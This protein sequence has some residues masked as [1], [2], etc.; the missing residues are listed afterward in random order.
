[1]V[2]DSA[3]H[4]P[5][6]GVVLPCSLIATLLHEDEVFLLPSVHRDGPDEA[7][8]RTYLSMSRRAVVTEEDADCCACPFRVLTP[9]VKADLHSQCQLTLFS[10]IR[11]LW[12]RI[13]SQTSL[14]T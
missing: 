13:L 9:A 2:G 10:G 4:H 1:M 12:A 11:N 8:A 14:S 6:F 3:F 7:D 5:V